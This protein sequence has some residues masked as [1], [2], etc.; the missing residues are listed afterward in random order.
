MNTVGEAV[1]TSFQGTEARGSSQ[2]QQEMSIEPGDVVTYQGDLWRVQIVLD[3][4]TLVLDKGGSRKRISARDIIPPQ[5]RRR[6][7][8]QAIDGMKLKNDRKGCNLG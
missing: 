6:R 7:K 4:H 5:D 8:L 3:E 1:K 2:G